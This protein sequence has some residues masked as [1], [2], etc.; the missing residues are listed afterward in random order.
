MQYNIHSFN[1]IE[2]SKKGLIVSSITAE[3]IIPN[4]TIDFFKQHYPSVQF[5]YIDIISFSKGCTQIECSVKMFK[6]WLLSQAGNYDFFIGFAYG[7]VVLQYS[8]DLLGDKKVI[9]ISSPEYMNEELD[10]KLTLL[11]K[12]LIKNLTYEAIDLLDSF[13]YTDQLSC[14]YKFNIPLKEV[15]LRLQNG[16]QMILTMEQFNNDSDNVM[17]L[18]GQNSKL[19]N[20]NSIFAQNNVVEIPDAGMRIIEENPH[21]VKETINEFLN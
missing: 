1:G 7:G 17:K 13:I 6:E 8:M 14:K 21:K 9:L 18:V 2:S 10:E 5:D 19:V 20:I 15:N 11:K 12:M 4:R 16:F 3:E